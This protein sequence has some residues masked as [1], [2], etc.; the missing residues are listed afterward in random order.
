[1]RLRLD[2]APPVREPLSE[3]RL[4]EFDDVCRDEASES[5]SRRAFSGRAHDDAW[6]GHYPAFWTYYP[7]KAGGALPDDTPTLGIGP[8]ERWDPWYGRPDANAPSGAPVGAYMSPLAACFLGTR[9][10]SPFAA[11][12]PPTA[13]TETMAE[14]LGIGAPQPSEPQRW[15][16]RQRLPVRMQQLE[17]VTDIPASVVRAA[18]RPVVDYAE[19]CWHRALED[20]A[21]PARELRV[22]VSVRANR[23]YASARGGSGSDTEIG[24]R[25]CLERAHDG[26]AEAL[27]TGASV[28]ARYRLALG[29]DD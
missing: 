6:Y 29:S 28:R 12:T 27:I 23:G 24:L 10:C 7:P 19:R 25:C 20:E 3:T 2:R 11:D 17:V 16:R 5:A 15:W 14:T 9:T 1:M 18:L 22:E 8:S 13:A 26:L 4:D 21:L